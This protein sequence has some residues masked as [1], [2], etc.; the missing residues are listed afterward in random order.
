MPKTTKTVEQQM[1]EIQ[2]QIR[3]ISLREEGLRLQR[4]R[5][6]NKVAQLQF[7]TGDEP[8]VQVEP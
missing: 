3:G 7:R 8:D 2:K 5:L 1:E 4:Q 6:E